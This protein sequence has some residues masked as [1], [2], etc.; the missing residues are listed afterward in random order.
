MQQSAKPA[1]SPSTPNHIPPP[2]RFNG[3]DGDVG[4]GGS[5][6][7]GNSGSGGGS[8][9]KSGAGAAVTSMRDRLSV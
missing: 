9:R 2:R 8:K 6:K 5:G 1:L 7:G 4:G 3:A